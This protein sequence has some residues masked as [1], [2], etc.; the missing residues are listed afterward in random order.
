[1]G[2]SDHNVPSLSNVAIRCGTGTNAELPSLVTRVTNSTMAGLAGPAFQLGRGPAACA[3]GC[4]PWRPRPGRRSSKAKSRT[5]ILTR[6]LVGAR[7][8][9]AVVSAFSRRT[10]CRARRVTRWRGRDP[11]E[12][13][14][15]DLQ[16]LQSN[17]LA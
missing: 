3:S 1:M 5:M 16:V 14:R 13:R 12:L 9:P 8:L 7:T 15:F 6:N 10:P 17:G 2:C 4:G 11:D